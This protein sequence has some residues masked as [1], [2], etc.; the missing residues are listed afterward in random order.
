ML[1]TSVT[2]K[3]SSIGDVLGSPA[4]QSASCRQVALSSLG[5]LIAST[6]RRSML[7]HLSLRQQCC[8][9]QCSVASAA[10]AHGQG[11]HGSPLSK[12][13]VRGIDMEGMSLIPC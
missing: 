9:V 1:R 6:A 5:L 13:D 11:Q 7:Q 3:D 2:F 10:G 4:G 12:R 8:T